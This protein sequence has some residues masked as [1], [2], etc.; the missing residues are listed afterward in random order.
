MGVLRNLNSFWIVVIFL[1]F[2]GCKKDGSDSSSDGS[3]SSL[4]NIPIGADEI[5]DTANAARLEFEQT[6]IDWDT[7]RQG[8]NFDATFR[9]VNRGNRPALISAVRAS[10]GCTA[11]EYS[12]DPIPPGGSSDIKV[13]FNSYGREGYQKKSINVIGNTFPPRT[14]LYL[15]GFVEK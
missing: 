14:L 12:S 2:S 11:T 10:C 15:Q 9:F 8:E 13:T 5:I 7:I 6:L 1:I 4:V 3:V